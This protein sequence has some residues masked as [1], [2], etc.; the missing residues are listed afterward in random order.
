MTGRTLALALSA[1]L[2]PAFPAVA[3]D[4]DRIED[5]LKEQGLGPRYELDDDVVDD[6]EE[7][8]G[9]RPAR[10]QEAQGRRPEGAREDR[11]QAGQRGEREEYSKSPEAGSGERLGHEPR[12]FVFMI[13]DED[14]T[15]WTAEASRS[16]QMARQDAAR[17]SET[18]LEAGAARD[19][20]DRLQQEDEQQQE[21][22]KQARKAGECARIEGTIAEVRE[23]DVEGYDEDHDMLKVRTKDGLVCIVDLGPDDDSLDLDLESGDMVEVEG[24]HGEINGQKVL[25]A[26]EVSEKAR[27]SWSGIPLRTTE[28]SGARQ[29]GDTG[30]EQDAGTGLEQDSGEQKDR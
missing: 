11:A 30:Q 25:F 9:Y 10:D 14:F 2:L 17:R 29:P 1:L 8:D 19:D 16:E 22:G 18:T 3:Q 21:E 27:V 20:Q 15:A 28:G 5:E 13:D 4:V 26:H 12:Q 6:R 24:E 23:F 7:D